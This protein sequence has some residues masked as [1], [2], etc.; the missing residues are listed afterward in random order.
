MIG[1]ELG[2]EPKGGSMKFSSVAWV[3]DDDSQRDWSVAA[4]L[5]T[6]WVRERCNE[7]GASA[8]LVTNAL[9]YL[10]VAELDDF[11]RQYTRTSRRAGRNRV[12]RGVGPVLSYVPY[13]EDL[14]FAMRLARNSSIAVVETVAFPIGGWAARLGA[15]NLVANR[16]TPPL[17]EAVRDAVDRLKFYGN[18]GF[19]D[20]FGKR[21]A[22]SILGG[23]R[24]DGVLDR[25]VLLGAVLAAGLSARGTANLAGLLDS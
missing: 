23:L 3:P 6:H 17:T 5:A 12:Q 20:R 21:Q 7:E 1:D 15:W 22:Q 18:N 4:G 10:G 14:E 9:D 8:V 16:K 2:L 11:E 19:G 25:D 13:A 24:T